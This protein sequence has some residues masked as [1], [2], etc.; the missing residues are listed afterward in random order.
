MQQGLPSVLQ[1]ITLKSYLSKDKRE[2]YTEIL[3]WSTGEGRMLQEDAPEAKKHLIFGNNR[4]VTKLQ[5][6]CKGKSS[7]QPQG[8]HGVWRE[9]HS[10]GSMR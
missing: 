10:S 2:F 9:G 1:K 7:G 5:K 8:G 6:N 3:G 4:R